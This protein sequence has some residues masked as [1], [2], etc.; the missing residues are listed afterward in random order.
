MSSQR[1][2]VTI[3]I[4]LLI[5][6][7]AAAIGI[8]G[9]GLAPSGQP[10]ATATVVSAQQVLTIGN[11]TKGDKFELTVDFTDQSGRPHTAT[12]FTERHKNDQMRAQNY[13]GQRLTVEYDPAD[14][15]TSAKLQV[16]RFP[17]WS[18]FVIALVAL[19]LAG[20]TFVGVDV[21]GLGRLA[22]RRFNIDVR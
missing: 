15:M 3:G 16:D 14:P 18:M 21:I 1:R 4:T 6:I 19:A 8:T 2:L 11:N 9:F 5:A 22:Q 7:A 20:A 10:T 17:A 12:V 13:V